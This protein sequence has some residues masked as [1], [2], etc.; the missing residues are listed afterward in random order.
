MQ[1][2][3][4][5]CAGAKD[6]SP[7]ALMRFSI[8]FNY[9]MP[10]DVRLFLKAYPDHA[11]KEIQNCSLLLHAVK[12]GHLEMAKAFV[13]MGANVHATGQNKWSKDTKNNILHMAVMSHDPDMLAYALSLPLKKEINRV[14]TLHETPLYRALM[15]NEE[16]EEHKRHSIIRQLLDRGADTN[17]GTPNGVTPLFMAAARPDIPMIE[18]LL[19]HKAEIT[20]TMRQCGFPPESMKILQKEHASRVGKAAA[21]GLRENLVPAP[22]IRLPRSAKGNSPG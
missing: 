2:Y 11:N 14:N 18:L 20:E 8:A 17:K 5:K 16:V 7:E 6:P 10:E 13:E 21:R 9:N 22:K 15:L 3:L 1:S 12:N 4:D 19:A